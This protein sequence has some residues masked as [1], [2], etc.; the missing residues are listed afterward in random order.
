MCPRRLRFSRKQRKRIELPLTHLLTMPPSLPPSHLHNPNKVHSAKFENEKDTRNIKEAIARYKIEH[1]VVNDKDMAMFTAVGV[2]S[3]PSLVLVGPRG[4]LLSI[5]PGEGNFEKVDSFIEGALAFYGEKGLLNN[6]PLKISKP[7]SARG[8]LPGSPLSYP[9]KLHV[10]PQQPRL[11]VSD[12]GNNRVLVLDR[13]TGGL[14]AAVGSATGE[15]GL[16]DGDFESARFSNPQG[17]CL[18]ANGR[19]LYVCDT[20]AHAIRA[21]DLEK[22]VVTTVAGNGEQG[23]DYTGGKVGKAQYLSSPLDVVLKPF[24]SSLLV[25]MAGTHQIWEVEVPSGK[26][27]CYSGTGREAETNAGDRINAAWAQPSGLTLGGQMLYV[28]D[29]ESR[30]VIV[31]AKG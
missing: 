1:P 18:S 5:W 27:R 20:D 21:I 17:V 24:S 14:L 2:N 7:T 19:V 10:D 8:G 31:C 13:N 4:N 16:E 11:F 15:P 28:A 23:F 25:A 3:W 12:S 26:A 29:S 6:T 30:Y 9:G 22:K